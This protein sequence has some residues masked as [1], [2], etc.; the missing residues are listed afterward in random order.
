V[1]PR[2]GR[3]YRRV[4]SEFLVEVYVSRVAAN[5]AAPPAEA[6]SVA[7]EKMTREG[8][9]VRFLRSIFVPED[10]TCF[11]LYWAQSAEAV[12]EAAT[13][14]GLRFERVSKVVSAQPTPPE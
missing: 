14:A 9:A 1:S 12:H 13:R 3:L 2:E 6:V 4:M 5:A 11:Y 10:E 8:T 7:A